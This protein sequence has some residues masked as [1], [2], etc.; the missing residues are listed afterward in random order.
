MKAHVIRHIKWNG[1]VS[2]DPYILV[3]TGKKLYRMP[4]GSPR[5][6]STMRRQFPDRIEHSVTLS[7][8]RGVIEPDQD[9]VRLQAGWPEVFEVLEKHFTFD[10]EPSEFLVEVAAELSPSSAQLNRLRQ[11]CSE[12]INPRERALLQS[13]LKMSEQLASWV[14]ED[15][16]RAA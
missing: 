2:F 1:K 5:C 6:A 15:R 9:V 4:G 14:K 13:Y 10:F 7:E 3:V 12:A 8:H 11:R 16:E